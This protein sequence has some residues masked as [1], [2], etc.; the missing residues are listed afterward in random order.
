MLSVQLVPPERKDA[1]DQWDLLGLL[2]LLVLPELL[3]RFLRLLSE[4]F[5]DLSSTIIKLW[6]VMYKLRLFVPLDAHSSAEGAP[7][8]ES[9]ALTLH[10]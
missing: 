2:V 6:S 10:L 4:K 5:P 8:W 7:L 9:Q 1:L 3:E